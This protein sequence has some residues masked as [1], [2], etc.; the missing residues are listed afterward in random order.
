MKKHEVPLK[1]Q[2]NF[3]KESKQVVLRFA[4]VDIAEAERLN[5]DFQELFRQTLKKALLAFK[6]DKQ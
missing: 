2:S 1:L 3:T 5:I 4:K 6:G